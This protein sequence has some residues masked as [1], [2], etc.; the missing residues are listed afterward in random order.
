M[1][2]V[3]QQTGK[4]APPE[5]LGRRISIFLSHTIDR[6]RIA[7]WV[8]LIAAAV[9]LVGYFVY[10]EV[11]K[12]LAADSTVLAESAQ[13]AYDKWQTENDATKK[14]EDQK[15]LQSQL[16]RL[17]G[18][19]PHQYGG[20]RGLYLRASL[21]YETKQWD[22]AAKDYQLLARRFPGSYLAPI[23]EFNAAI[24][25]DEKGDVDGALALYKSIPQSYK[26]STVAPRALFDAGRLEEQKSAWD[27]AQKQYTA[28]DTDYP[29][30]DWNQLAKDRLIEL[31]VLGKIK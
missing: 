12:K 15:D 1:Q 31:K 29:Q 25:L 17:V 8:I 2:P 9:F 14:A 28:I 6:F 4:Q 20:Q 21:A 19:Y 18:R 5:H 30:S 7:L 13:S 27:D 24:A 22:P 23:S 26:N 16:D 11:T 10:T 3:Q